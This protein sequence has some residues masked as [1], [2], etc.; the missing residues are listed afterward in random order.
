MGCSGEYTDPSGTTVV[1]CVC[2][3]ILYVIAM[4]ERQVS[5]AGMRS[6]MADI[7]HSAVNP[8]ML[9][10]GLMIVYVDMESLGGVLPSPCH[11][12]LHEKRFQ[13]MECAKDGTCLLSWCLIL[14]SIHDCACSL[15]GALKFNGLLA[16]HLRGEW[17][18]ET[19]RHF[20]FV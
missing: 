2:C 6:A 16:C 7:F 3:Q 10:P 8:A 19:S 17:E 1:A 9:I 13:E 14:K 18:E 11:P 12:L 20:V 5:R 15:Q 4:I